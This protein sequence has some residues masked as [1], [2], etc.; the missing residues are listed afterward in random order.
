[1]VNRV[2][3]DD[4]SK[5]DM[6]NR[7]I[8]PYFYFCILT[9]AQTSCHAVAALG[10]LERLRYVA[11]LPSWPELVNSLNTGYGLLDLDSQVSRLWDI[12]DEP[13]HHPGVCFVSHTADLLDMD[14]RTDQQSVH[15]RSILPGVDASNGHC[16]GSSPRRQGI[17]LVK[18][19]IEHSPCRISLYTCYPWLVPVS[20]MSAMFESNIAILQSLLQAAMLAQSVLARLVRHCITCACRPP[21]SLHPMY[22]RP[23]SHL[24]S[25]RLPCSLTRSTLL[26]THLCIEGAIKCSSDSLRITWS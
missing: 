14:Q 8:T 4:P 24:S 20:N 26:R 1:M 6:H 25:T 21:I 23:F 5:G 12:R 10:S 11:D 19:H 13:S 7:Y 18:I 22:V 9:V 15:H 3:R 16:V 2:I 17:Q